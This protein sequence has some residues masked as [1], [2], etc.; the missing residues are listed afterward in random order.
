MYALLLEE[1]VEAFKYAAEED[2]VRHSKK[3]L[4]VLEKL[5]VDKLFCKCFIFRTE[6]LKH[7]PNRS[8]NLLDDLTVHFIVHFMQCQ[9]SDHVNSAVQAFN[10]IILD[11]R[12][13]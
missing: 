11:K 6:P 13:L 12:V 5:L 4:Q 2:Q 8:H 10:T 7:L 3:Q 1:D 9:R